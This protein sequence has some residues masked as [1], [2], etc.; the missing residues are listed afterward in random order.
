MLTP[1]VILQA[2]LQLPRPTRTL[3]SFGLTLSMC[4][5]APSPGVAPPQGPS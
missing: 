1:V 2:T 4:T 3:S 5:Q